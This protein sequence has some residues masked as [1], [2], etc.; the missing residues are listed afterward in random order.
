LLIEARSSDEVAIP[1]M[2]A[3]GYGRMS[4][5]GTLQ[6]ITVNDVAQP[7]ATVTVKSAHGGTDVE[8]VLVVGNAPVEAANQPPLAQAD[9]GST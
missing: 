8:P 6:S 5:S 4:K 2:L 9:I 7:P 1:D 3:Q